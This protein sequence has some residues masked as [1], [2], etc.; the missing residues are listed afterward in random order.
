MPEHPHVSQIALSVA[1]AARSERFYGDAFGFLPAGGTRL[2]GRTASRVMGL[3]NVDAHCRWLVGRDELTQLELL[4]FTSP[5]PARSP[6]D[7][8]PCDIG[9]ARVGLYVADFDAALDRLCALGSPP[10]TDPLGPRG[11]RRVCVRDPDGV[12]L[13]LMEDDP[14][15]PSA[16]PPARPECPVALRSVTLSVPNLDRSKAFFAGALGMREAPPDVLHTAS[17]ESLWGLSPAHTRRATSVLRAGCVFVEL[18]QTIEPLG[19]PRPDTY[20]LSDIGVLNIAL[21]FSE[22]STFRRAY[23]RVID[24]G[25][26]SHGKP[27]DVGWY[28]VVYCSDDQGFSVEL[29]YIHPWFNRFSGYMP[30]QGKA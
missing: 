13:E 19:R 23:Q 27:L 25:Y 5:A 4:Q 14:G 10:L 6:E 9:Y 8:R 11:A 26:T 22:R 30:R 1:D 15:Q 24:E 12:L 21:G 18:V 29:L 7:R 20:R 3:P 17:M 16:R 2:R 28:V